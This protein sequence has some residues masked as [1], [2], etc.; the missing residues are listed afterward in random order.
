MTIIETIR[1]TQRYMKL[2]EV[3]DIC[4]FRRGTARKWAQAGTFPAF[5]VNGTWMCK[6]AKVAEWLEVRQLSPLVRGQQ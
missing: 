5:R 2:V 3:F 6:P 4:G 1:R